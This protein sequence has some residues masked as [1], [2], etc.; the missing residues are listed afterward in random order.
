MMGTA[1]RATLTTAKREVLTLHSRQIAYREHR[2]TGA[3]ILLVHGIGSSS[4]TWNPVFDHLVASGAP[5][6]AV[7]LPG[8]GESSKQPGDYSLGSMA[9]T[10]RDLLDHL[11]HD[12]V[13]LVGHSLGG[14]ISLQ[15]VYQFPERVRTLTLVSSGGLG[16]ETFGGLRAAAM[17]GSEIALRWAI[18]RRTLA[19][20]ARLG[21]VLSRVGVEPHALSP[22]ALETVSW[23]GDDERRAAFLATLRSVVGV[24][25]QRVSALDKLHL[26][27]GH[28]V[29]IIWGDRD[30]MIPM[31]HG[32][33]AH[34]LLEGS[35]FVTFAEAAHEPH[36][37]DSRRFADL[38]LEHTNR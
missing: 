24:K 19:G 7:D 21:R 5:V 1:D 34:A 20:A 2:G 10:L 25:G 32:A 37:H 38:V 36:M 3:P 33:H 18:N 26:L 8:H 9:S 12:R 17:P 13:H 30:P 16:E 6:I 31:A 14:G 28:Q 35:R 29:L 15:F 22:G 4:D 27:D 11:G 23:L